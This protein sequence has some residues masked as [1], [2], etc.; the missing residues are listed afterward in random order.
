MTGRKASLQFPQQV[1]SVAHYH[2]AAGI[3]PSSRVIPENCEYIELLT[4]GRGWCLCDGQ[5]QEVT[6]GSLLWHVPGDP[7]IGRSDPEKPYRCLAVSFLSPGMPRKRQVP[8]LTQ[9]TD[10]LTVRGFTHEVVALHVNT[11]L[12]RKAFTAYL[13]SRL[14]MQARLGER[15][16]AEVG[17][18][19]PF[20]RVSELIEEECDRELT[21]EKMAQEAGVS[22]SHFH[23]R[24]REIFGQSPHRALK[25]RRIRAARQLLAGTDHPVKYIAA[26]CG[27][28]DV[29]SFCHTFRKETGE[30]PS[31]YRVRQTHPF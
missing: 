5:W 15:H 9:W 8:H 14:L 12:D 20:R 29:S 7:T 3:Q 26:Q 31:N 23:A 25:A 17:V 4:G 11:D 1:I 16:F 2:Q 30:T 24:F 6:A 13:Y 27:F 28:A 21:I 22:V 19:E 10:I 18:P